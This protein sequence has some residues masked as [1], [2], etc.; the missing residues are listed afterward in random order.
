MFH[1]FLYHCYAGSCVVL[2]AALDNIVL[3]HEVRFDYS[4]R[5]DDQVKLPILG[6]QSR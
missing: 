2:Q 6:D 3:C 4:H 1:T 5:N